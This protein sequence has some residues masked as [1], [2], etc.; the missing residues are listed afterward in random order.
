MRARFGCARD[1][2]IL[3][4]RAI[5]REDVLPR[6]LHPAIL[7]RYEAGDVEPLHDPARGVPL[8]FSH[9]AFRIGHVMARESYEFSDVA[10][11]LQNA[12]SL[13]SR[14]NEIWPLSADWMIDWAAFYDLDPGRAPQRSRR[15]APRAAPPLV[16]NNI[17]FPFVDSTGAG[18]LIYRDLMSSALADLWSV[19]ALLGRIRRTFAAE[20][21]SS[22][23]LED[24][25]QR[26]SLIEMFLR[27][28]EDR[29]GDFSASDLTALAQ[30]P[31]LAF[32]V[33][34]EAIADPGSSGER[35]G[36]LG[37]ILVADVLFGALRHSRPQDEGAGGL[38]QAI[39]CCT[40]RWGFKGMPGPISEIVTMEKVI[41]FAVS[42]G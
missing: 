17:F 22:P 26:R 15:L 42:G 8:E 32:F 27:H 13:T 25:K 19:D 18:G 10:Q 4:Y 35:L 7:K 36:V 40:K 20:I 1:V 16:E 33:M 38:R 9:A 3:I 34:F 31:P 41:A 6:L 28:R 29:K 5:I 37:S 23:I 30:D 21:A 11:P 2:M 24:A 14:R 39:D 12:L